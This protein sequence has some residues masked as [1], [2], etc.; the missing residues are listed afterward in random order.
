[1][2]DTTGDATTTKA[3]YIKKKKLKIKYVSPKRNDF[4][5]PPV[6]EDL[7]WFLCSKII[8]KL[9]SEIFFATKDFQ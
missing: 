8:S 7:G 4:S 6:K 1:V 3:H 9:L 2:S 5:K